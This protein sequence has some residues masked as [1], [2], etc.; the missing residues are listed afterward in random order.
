MFL[1]LKIGVSVTRHPKNKARGTGFEE[2]LA[3]F[4]KRSLNGQMSKIRFFNFKC[5]LF[6]EKKILHLK[7]STNFYTVESKKK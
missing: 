1:V 7:K 2:Q 6:M 4:S 3:D 5:E